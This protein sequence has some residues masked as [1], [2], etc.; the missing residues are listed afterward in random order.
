MSGR[1]TTGS[2]VGLPRFHRWKL[3]CGAR[4]RCAGAN[5]SALEDALGR[6]DPSSAVLNER[7]VA[8]ITGASRNMPR[9]TAVASFL[10]LP[11][12]DLTP[13]GALSSVWPTS[14]TPPAP[15]DPDY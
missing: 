6:A 3:T 14:G 8:L 1:K 12:A 11:S 15:N 7:K 10:L 9:L 13:T 4:R 2:R 5:G